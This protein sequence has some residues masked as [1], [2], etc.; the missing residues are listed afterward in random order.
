MIE[1]SGGNLLQA[2]L[3]YGMIGGGPGSFIGDVH[4]KAAAFDGN[5]MLVAGCF[6][7]SYENTLQTGQSLGISEDRLYENVYMMAHAEAAR[8]DGIKF[9][10]ITSP[11]YNHYDAAK[12][13]LEHGIHVVCEKPLVFEIAQAEELIALA[14]A[15]DLLFCVMYSYSGSPMM[16]EAREIVRSGKIGTVLT[17]VGEYAQGWL[18]QALE[19]SDQKQ[20]SWRTDPSIAGISNCIGDIGSHIEHTVSFITGLKIK[21]LCARLETIGLDRLLDTNASVLLEYENG[22]SGNYWASQI[23]IGCDNRLVV[24]IYGTKGAI[25]W[26]QEDGN[27]LKVT[28]L[29]QP[30]Q[31]FSRG[32]GYLSPAAANRIPS[33]HPEGYYEAF[34]N[35]YNQFTLALNKKI[36]G[37]T[38][39][40]ADLDFPD[41]D[42]GLDGVKFINACVESSK[43]DASWV[44]LGL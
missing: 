23:A 34:A 43:Q 29:D 15:K 32:N 39:T 30:T 18:A 5:C 44:H 8:P 31:I 12:A 20:A 10:S 37:Q 3:S 41:G 19:K 42:A 25:E 17:V 7:N 40:A 24:R 13:F 9:V 22:A 38:L 35:V 11:N 14:K 1:A 16:R 26:Y 36:A 6:S 4:R 2:K 28:Y 33:G 27:Y 21:R